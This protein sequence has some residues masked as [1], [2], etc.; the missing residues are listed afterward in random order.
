MFFVSSHLFWTTSHLFEQLL[1]F[2]QEESQTVKDERKDHGAADESS[3]EQQ[4]CELA[5]YTLIVR[6]N[7]SAR[8]S[9]T[10]SYS[11]QA[12]RQ[13]KSSYHS[14]FLKF[15]REQTW[16]HYACLNEDIALL[17][18]LLGFCFLICIMLFIHKCIFRKPYVSWSIPNIKY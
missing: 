1:T 12:G 4:I 6:K 2:F 10:K 5:D 8:P 7:W 13:I 15:S 17:V 16:K 14:K 9:A 3:L 11:R 18:A